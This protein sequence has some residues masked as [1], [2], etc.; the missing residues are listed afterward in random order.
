MVETLAKF[1]VIIQRVGC[2]KSQQVYYSC[3]FK[4]TNI[5]IEVVNR[6]RDKLLLK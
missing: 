2:Q 6:V 1:K 3:F 4:S 5:L